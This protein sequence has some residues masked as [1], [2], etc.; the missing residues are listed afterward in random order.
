MQRQETSASPLPQ[1]A[2]GFSTAWAKPEVG[3]CACCLPAARRG[4]ALSAG[5]FEK[6]LDQQ[7]HGGRRIVLLRIMR[8]GVFR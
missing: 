2:L 7:M 5:V 6:F 8:G 4:F 3:R 1:N